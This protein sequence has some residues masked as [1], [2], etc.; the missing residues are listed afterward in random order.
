VVSF[1]LDKAL[2]KKLTRPLPQ[3]D[4]GVVR[5]LVEVA[6]SH[7]GE[8]WLYFRVVLKD[9]DDTATVTTQPDEFGKRLQTISTALRDRAARLNVP[10]F[11]SVDFVGESELP[12]PKRKTA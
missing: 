1:V 12:R 7:V 11:A 8:D 4:K 6:P 5:I 9:D 10:M 2:E 3:I